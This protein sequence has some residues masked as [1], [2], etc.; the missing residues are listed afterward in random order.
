VELLTERFPGPV[1]R[2]LAVFSALL[3]CV[4]LWAVCYFSAR[5][6]WLE[7]GYGDRT[8]TLGIPIIAYWIPMLLGMFISGFAALAAGVLPLLARAP[9]QR[10]GV[11]R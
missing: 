1:Q 10:P 6:A 5:Q 11:P 7:F 8:Q 2:C 3:S 4:F 9:L